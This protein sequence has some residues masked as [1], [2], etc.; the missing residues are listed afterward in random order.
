MA[1]HSPLGATVFTDG[2]CSGNPGP[3]GWAAVVARPEGRV[4]ELGGFAPQ[5]T[6]NRM[7][8][9]AAIEALTAL[10][11]DAGPVLLWT[12]SKYVLGAA[13]GWIAGWKRRGWRKADGIP[14][15][16]QDLWERLDPLLSARIVWRYVPG[17]A[18]NLGNT[19]ADEI[20]VAFSK[21]RPV[22]LYDG[23]R[24]AYP[25][26]EREPPTSGA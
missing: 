20:A 22:T 19:R 23:P 9:I 26:L 13:G 6:N 7:E 4:H 16:N 3:G 11:T 21:G 18:G 15:L 8:I 12:D 10:G 25:Y 5:T 1:T 2:A 17:H 24:A 14:V